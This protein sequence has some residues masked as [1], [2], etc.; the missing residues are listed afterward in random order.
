M[1]IGLGLL[2]LGCSDKSNE[3]ESNEQTNIEDLEIDENCNPLNIGD[4]CFL[5]FPSL[6]FTTSDSTSPTGIR[7]NY[8][9]KNLHIP[10]RELTFG[11]DMVNIA[12]GTSPLSP[13][14][15]NFGIDIDPAFLSGWNEQEETVQTGAP[16]AL[17]HIAS[18]ELVPIHTEMDQ[19]NRN[20]DDYEDRHPLIIRPLAPM[21][22]GE[23]YMV[24]LSN[25]LTDING[26]PLPRSKVFDVLQ[27]GTITSNTTIEGMR[28]RYEDLFSTVESAGWER[29]NLL[30]MW[31]FQVASEQ[32][33]LGPARTIRDHIADMNPN[34]IEFTIDELIENPNEH[35]AFLV[36]GKFYPPNFLDDESELVLDENL[37]PVEQE[38]R[39]G[40]DFT[41]AVPIVAL[42]R[43]NLGLWLMGHGLFGEGR[44]MIDG[45]GA[46]QLM[47]PWTNE[48]EAILI[49]TDWI[50]LSG[51]DRELIINEVIPNLDRL[52]LV[53][54]RLAQSHANN[55]ALVELAIHGLTEGD[56]LPVPHDEPL[57]T[58]DNVFYYG[59]SLGGIQGSGQTAL[60]P[61]IS[62][63]VVAVP[64]AGWVNLIQRSTQFEPLEVLFD[65]LYPDPLTQMVLL[66]AAQTFFDWSDPGNLAQLIKNPDDPNGIEKVVIIQESIGDCQVSNI[67]TDLLVRS[68][69]AKHLEE[70][71]DPIFGVE[72]VSAPYKGT[73]ITQIRV[74]NDL[75]EFFPLD[76]N[77]TPEVDNGVH[78]SGVLRESI[79]EQVSHLYKYGE[80]IHPCEG[81]CDPD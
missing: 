6:H 68:M 16:I 21:K 46:E 53:T 59:I 12:D 20:W 48:L 17:V 33:V 8:Q 27:E 51:G 2:L 54:D 36:K 58:G 70:A 65:N 40:Y 22:F 7:L 81:P 50:G 78:N 75:A 49:A 52:R 11:L 76:A 39:F 35:L 41:M 1:F 3:K 73:A 25:K 13:A 67:T 31:D 5:P 14:M 42:E 66:G 60:S 71:T 30:L 10:D 61:R 69:G 64:G 55:L 57:L 18:G 24:V 79:F 62:R 45:N 15:I 26:D 80:L 77:V 72:T 47:H 29:D 4:D 23:K 38:T 34:T 74:E 37:F 43:G 63:S 28:S 32:F 56:V 19:A 44:P 9:T